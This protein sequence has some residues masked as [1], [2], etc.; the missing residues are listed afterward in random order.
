MAPARGG[1]RTDRRRQCRTPVA[2]IVAVVLVTVVVAVA[3]AVG[4]PTGTRPA[5][6]AG[7]SGPSLTLL[8]PPT[9]AGPTAPFSVRLGVSAGSTYSQLTLGLT[10]YEHVSDPTDFDQT[11]KGS[12]VESVLARSD[13]IALSSLIP[14]AGDPGAGV[15]LTVPV[16]AGGVTGPGTGPFTADLD[17]PIGQCTGVYPLLFTLTD[18]ATGTE[19]RLLSYLVFTDPSVDNEKLRMA[20]VVPLALPSSSSGAPSVTTAGLTSLTDE[21]RAVSGAQAGVPVTLAP[22]PATVAALAA[23]PD[24]RAKALLSSLVALTAEPYRQ[25]LCGTF[26]PVNASVLVT[27]RL[28]GATELAAQLHR[29]TEVLDGVPGLRTTDCAGANVWVANGTLESAALGALAALGDNDVVV[30]PGSVAGPAP[31]I[32]PTRRFTLDGGRR[33]GNAVMSDPGLSGRLAST[34]TTD[35]ALA[36]DQLLAEAE[37][38]YYEA[39]NTPDARGVVVTPPSGGQIDP[40]VLTDVLTG[41]ENNPMVD[42]VTLATLFADVPVGGTVAGFAELSNRRPAG[43]DSTAGLPTAALASARAQLT[44]F[45][46]AVA[47]SSATGNAIVSGLGDLLLEAESDQLTSAQQRAAVGHFEDA[48]RHQLSVLSITSHEVRLTSHTASV[49]ITV[50]KTAPY[51]VQAVLTVTSDKIAFSSGSAQPANAECRRPVVTNSDGRSSVSSLCTFVHGTNAVYIEMRSRVSGDFRMSVTL[52]SPQAG[53]ALASGE[54]TVR[55]LS[56]SVV[57][58]VLTVVAGAVLLGWWGRT[59]RRTR[60]A[61]GAHRQRADAP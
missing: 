52:D 45:S 39:P 15:D 33:T 38:D 43:V 5:G 28:G 4:T 29:G 40:T 50:V 37:L 17:C 23:D 11:L 26:V 34:S 44:G 31:S 46:A 56:T 51:P 42:P 1:D 57:A 3:L 53:L 35:P 60:R 30:P 25:T 12:P 41:L 21:L 24:A 2:R 19:A 32:T 36:A 27:P 6:A 10:L 54:I 7:P 13:A 20:V 61:R 18:T 55:S 14:D 58:I 8:A 9:I 48:L 49:P 59:M 16:T 22:E 47:G